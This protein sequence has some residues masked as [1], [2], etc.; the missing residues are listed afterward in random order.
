MLRVGLL[1]LVFAVPAAAADSAQVDAAVRRGCD[2][3]RKVHAPASG[4][5]GGGEHGVGTAALGGLAMIEGKVPKDDP[6][7]R[8]IAD[9]IRV[10]ALSETQTYRVSLALIFF[11]KYGDP[12]DVPLLQLLGIRLYHGMNVSAGWTY[13]TWPEVPPVEAERLAAVLRT[14]APPGK[15]HPE[16]VRQFQAVQQ[17]VATVG[18]S[19]GSD[20]NSNTQFGLI[21]LW[22]AARHKVPVYGALLALEGRFLRTQNRTD[23]GWGYTAAEASAPAMTC[24]GLLALAAGAALRETVR[25]GKNILT[26]DAPDEVPAEPT[27][28]S[29]EPT[30]PFT[31]PRERRAVPV[32]PGKAPPPAPPEPEPEAVTA[33]ARSLAVQVGLSAV[34]RVL[35]ATPAPGTPTGAGPL[36]GYVSHGNYFY[37]LWSVERIGVAFGLDT[38][39]NVG[40]YDWG[41]NYLLPNQGADGAWGTS[42]MYGSSVNTPFAVLFLTR[43]NLFGEMGRTVKDKY[44]DPGKAELRGGAGGAG[45]VMTAPSR[46]EPNAPPLPTETAFDPTAVLPTV[47]NT[48]E[49]WKRSARLVTATDEEWPDRL[50]ELRD[51]RGALNTLALAQAAASLDGVRRKQAR[52]TLADRLVRMT[53]ATLR[54]LMRDPDPEIRRAAVLACGVK[55]DA[56]FVPDLI[57]RLADPSELVGRAARASLKA[58]TQKDFGPEPGATEAVKLK[59]IEDWQAWAKTQGGTSP[60]R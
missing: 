27:K 25:T 57:G 43:A 15:A 47:Q 19:A 40:W 7:L 42:D 21:G 41:C 3:L 16:V 56:G 51:S 33:P 8:N 39:G 52:D 26:P 35:A 45:P 55:A 5:A 22:V 29:A 18:R 44:K 13:S 30:D 2:Y 9:F 1:A 59:A 54:G 17:H 28:K 20:D 36:A 37:V 14:P 11:D 50:V 48:E 24:A 12:K 53:P 32:D 10:R 58:L 31:N 60:K 23:G 46:P 4:Y 49:A 6:A 34:G 38:I